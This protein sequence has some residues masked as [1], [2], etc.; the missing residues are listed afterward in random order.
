MVAVQNCALYL[1]TRQM[2]FARTL[3]S[4]RVKK[5]LTGVPKTFSFST[6]EASAEF[7]FRYRPE[8]DAQLAGFSG[9]VSQLPNLEESRR[10]AKDRIAA[11]KVEIGVRLSH[12][13]SLDGAAFEAIAAFAFAHRGFVF[14]QD[15]IL[16]E[17]GY[18]VG[19]VAQPQV[20]T[21]AAASFKVEMPDYHAS[22]SEVAKAV[23]ARTLAELT[24]AGFRPAS[25]LPFPNVEAALRPKEEIAGRFCSLLN[26]VLFVVAP[27]E[28]SPETEL[29]QT[30]D[31]H[32]LDR[33]LTAEEKDI[34]SLPRVDAHTEHIN[35]IGWRLE[36]MLALAWIMGM[37]PKP[38]V[39]AE[40]SG[41][42]EFDA[43]TRLLPASD[44]SW[45]DFLDAVT[46]RGVDDVIALED[47]FYCA[48]NAVRSAQM[49]H[50]TVPRGFHPVGNGGVIHERRH[51]L[52]W[53][54][55]PDV[56]WGDTDL[57]T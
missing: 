14:V 26:L 42:N 28:R 38:A 6:S 15:S 34:L 7:V 47:V 43:M 2:D 30:M 32:H 21:Q 50:P 3:P 25:S 1:P 17:E 53:A 12:P 56:D 27:E 18:L 16:T 48:H 54:L 33:F 40:M 44:T 4:G 5:S 52:T 24:V 10:D 8:I 31:K 13:V 45:P 57:S 49:G 23:R 19:P 36:N 20:F 37:E 9:Y 22:A 41:G 39:S 46:L 29:R 51:A 35:S 55:S 11:V